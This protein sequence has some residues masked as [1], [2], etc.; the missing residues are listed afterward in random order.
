M[1]DK[2]NGLPTYPQGQTYGFAAPW[3]GLALL[4][5]THR[6]W[7][8]L[9]P[10]GFAGLH[11]STLIRN[12]RFF[13]NG[14]WGARGQERGSPCHSAPVDRPFCLAEG[15]ISQG[16][17]FENAKTR[18]N[19]QTTRFGKRAINS[20]PPFPAN[21]EGWDTMN[22]FYGA[23]VRKIVKTAQRSSVAQKGS[24]IN[25]SE[26]KGRHVSSRPFP[27]GYHR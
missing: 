5:P 8:R 10:S 1:M 7:I 16:R 2:P 17:S 26:E 27:P 9:R 19:R 13:L 11:N 22:V 12:Q 15:W 20:T 3:I 21:S 24:I 4:R 6:S 23:Q 18:V 14:I 25:Q